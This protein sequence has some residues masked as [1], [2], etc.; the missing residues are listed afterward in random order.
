MI[1]EFKEVQTPE[2]NPYRPLKA[3]L[4]SNEAI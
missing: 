1:T 3:A 4:A 2:G